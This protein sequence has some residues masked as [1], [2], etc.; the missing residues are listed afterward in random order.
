[1]GA[2][3]IGIEELLPQRKYHKNKLVPA[4]EKT[5]CSGT[6]KKSWEELTIGISSKY[7]INM[8]LLMAEW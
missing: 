4:S 5:Y 7:L 8:Q 1:M 3:E 2:S 6:V